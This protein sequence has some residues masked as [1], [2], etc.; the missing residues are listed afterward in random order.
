MCLLAPILLFPYKQLAAVEILYGNSKICSK[1]I[2]NLSTWSLNKSSR[3]YDYF[4]KTDQSTEITRQTI[5]SNLATGYQNLLGYKHDDGSYT[6]WRPRPNDPV[7][8]NIWLT[9]YVARFLQEASEYTYIS[10]GTIDAAYNFLERKQSSGGYYE[11]TANDY[12]AKSH[13]E[14]TSFALIAFLENKQRSIKPT[15]K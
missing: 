2:R 3:I 1:I 15:S 7:Y 10:S 8:L 4:Q 6:I 13:L 5:V 14:L 11:Y 9:A 12:Y